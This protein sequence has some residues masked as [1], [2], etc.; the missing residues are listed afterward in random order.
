MITHRDGKQTK[1]PTEEKYKSKAEGSVI[2]LSLLQVSVTKGSSDWSSVF[3][4]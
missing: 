2:F 1:P 4:G 3:L